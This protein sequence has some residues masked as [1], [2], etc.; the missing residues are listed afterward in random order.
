MCQSCLYARPL[1]DCDSMEIQLTHPTSPKHPA[2]LARF[3]MPS[4]KKTPPLIQCARPVKIW[5]PSY[6]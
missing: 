1:L 6:R 3:K 2:H 5:D 4:Q